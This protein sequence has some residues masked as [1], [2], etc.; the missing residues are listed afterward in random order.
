MATSKLYTERVE[1]VLVAYTTSGDMVDSDIDKMISEVDS[2]VTAIFT[3]LAGSVR[4]NAVQREKS[5]NHFIKIRTI[6]VTDDPWVRGVGQVAKWFGGNIETF[7]TDKLKEAARKLG[8]DP[9]ATSRVIIFCE[10]IRK[11]NNPRAAS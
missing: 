11:A 10:R 3:Y 2:S 5:R 4:A 1:N 6:V 8:L 9:V 7:P